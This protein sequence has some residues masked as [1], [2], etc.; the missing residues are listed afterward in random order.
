M[1][2]IFRWFHIEALFVLLICTG[3][4]C[5]DP[6]FSAEDKAE[7]AALNTDAASKTYPI[8]PPEAYKDI[9][10][11]YTLFEGD[12]QIRI[13]ILDRYLQGLI[14]QTNLWTNGV[15]PFE[16]DA[17]VS[18]AHRNAMLA[19]M[20]DWEAVANVD[21]RPRNGDGNYVYIQNSTGNNSALG[22]QGG[23]QIINIYNWNMEF[24]MAHELGHC[25]G[26]THEHTRPS[27]DLSITI[28]WSNIQSAYQNQFTINS[29]PEY[30]PYDFDSLMHYDECAFSIDCA[31]GFT[32]AC[33]K[34][35]ITVLPPNQ[36]WQSQIGQR[37][38]LSDLDSLG[39]SF[40]YPQGNWRFVDQGYSGGVETGMFLTPYKKFPFGY[41]NTPTGGVLWIQPGTYN[42]NGTY[43]RAMTLEAPLGGVT[44]R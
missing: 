15:I 38:H 7:G 14:F 29:L 43:S 34:K 16:F 28:N 44:L 17:A 3:A 33:T 27:R 39:I 22:M 25:L 21:F 35:V 19:A 5:A 18:Q 2:T 6:V 11:G 31:A 10:P 40:L 30:G 12:I 4:L 13:E 41:T 32:C 36:S 1:G 24:V 8:A 23:K 9:P 20:A 42:S 37:D 26:L